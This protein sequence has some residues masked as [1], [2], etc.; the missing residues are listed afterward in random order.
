MEDI[1][2]TTSSRPLDQWLAINRVL[3]VYRVT[4]FLSCGLIAILLCILTYMSLRG[5]IVVTINDGRK[6]FFEGKR[7]NLP[8]TEKDVEDFV[9]SFI[10]IVYQWENLKPEEI[11][12]AGAPLMTEGL[13]EK[14]KSQL[15]NRTTKE[16][17]GKT[18][19]QSVTNL[20]VKV[21]DQSVVASFEKILR[22][23]GVPLIIP[24]ELELGIIRGSAS[25]FNPLGLFVNGIT[26][27]EG[28]GR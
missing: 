1:P 3:Q 9:H 24:S 10:G 15:E 16:F 5:P 4:S 14:L 8:I 22:L 17:A 28:S 20:K 12:N 26:E 23:N 13:Y 19:S 18:L 11:M 25:K 7:Q 6:Q 21:T 2:K 27:H